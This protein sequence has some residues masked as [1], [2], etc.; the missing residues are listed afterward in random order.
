[1][2]GGELLLEQAVEGSGVADDI[3]HYFL[4]LEAVEDGLVR[5]L[6]EFVVLAL[7]GDE[8]LFRVGHA[9]DVLD[10]DVLEADQFFKVG[11]VKFDSDDGFLQGVD[12]D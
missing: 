3:G 9:A 12:L 11:V 7:A 4:V 10:L 2:V 6:C 5:A 8:Y 1:M